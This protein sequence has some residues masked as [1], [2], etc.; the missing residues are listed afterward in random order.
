MM[1]SAIDI[2][3]RDWLRW[4]SENGNAP[5]FVRLVTG[6]ALLAC[7]PD[8]ILLRPVLVELKRRYPQDEPSVLPR[9]QR[10]ER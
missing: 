6:A 4:A 7:T 5:A 3:L 10:C 8:Y 2:E 9:S 1:N